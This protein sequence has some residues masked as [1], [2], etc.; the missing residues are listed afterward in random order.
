MIDVDEGKVIELLQKEM[1][2]IIVDGA[3]FMAIKF[4]QKHFKR[5]AIKHIFTRVDF[6]ADINTMVLVDIKDGFP[7]A[8]K[9][10]KC[11]IDK[12]VRTLRPGVKKGK[13]QSA[14]K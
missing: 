4:F 11:L 5:D 6:I 3:A 2:R 8:G 1:R 14:G 13:C 7:P 9:F 10:R 12:P